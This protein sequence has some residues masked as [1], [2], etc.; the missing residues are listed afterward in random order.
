MRARRPG[1]RKNSGISIFRKNPHGRR[2]EKS[3]IDY[4]MCDNQEKSQGPLRTIFSLKKA[5]SS[6]QKKKEKPKK[7]FRNLK[8]III[9]EN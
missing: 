6:K 8:I 5:F 3:R 7:L 1:V 2:G 9:T 4:T